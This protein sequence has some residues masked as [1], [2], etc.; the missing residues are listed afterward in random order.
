MA[1]EKKAPVSV[2]GPTYKGV[3]VVEIDKLAAEVNALTDPAERKKIFSA[4]PELELRFS[5]ENFD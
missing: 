3:P 1:D 5:A 2:S 4:H